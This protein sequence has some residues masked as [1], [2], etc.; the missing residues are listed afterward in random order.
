VGL[1]GAAA[2]SFV[3]RVNAGPVILRELRAEARRPVNHWLRVLAAGAGVAVSGIVTASSR[4]GPTLLG[5][6]LFA[7]LHTTLFITFLVVVPLMTADCVSQE[8]REGTLGLLFLTP[9]T[10]PDIIVGKSLVHIV[11]ALTLFLAAMPVLTLPFL[12]GGVGWRDVA[13]AVAFEGCAVLLGTAAGLL[14]TSKGGTAM[15]VMAWSEVYVLLLA[16]AFGAFFD[17]AFIPN[18][19]TPSF[20]PLAQLVALP[21][22]L[23]T[24]MFGTGGWSVQ[25]LHAPPGVRNAWLRVVGETALC[26]LALFCLVLVWS[27]RRLKRTWQDRGADSDQPGWVRFFSGSAFWRAVFRWNKSRTLDRNPIAWLQEYSWTARLTKWGWCLL[28]LVVEVELLTN[29]RRPYYVG[30][31][32][33]ATLAL[34]LGMSFSAV[35]SFRRERRSGLLELL[36]VT[37]LTAG[38]LIGGRLWGVWCHFFP[39]VAVLMVGW[40]GDW[41]LGAWLLVPARSLGAPMLAVLMTFATLPVIGLYFS[42]RRLH[43]LVAWM[44]TL[45][46]GLVLP[47]L[48]D[49]CVA[50]YS[51]PILAGWNRWDREPMTMLCLFQALIACACLVRL[52]ED[53]LHRNFEFCG[54]A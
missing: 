53:L 29:W 25:F 51:R 39:A 52:Y 40:L 3:A 15:Q 1:P 49:L 22:V 14:A 47:F 43:L 27:V 46:A 36:L 6:S 30:W 7:D 17:I 31:Q 28:I 2:F 32:P 9:L 10:A 48:I 11:R 50:W 23:C 33:W 13:T 20:P 45:A 42:V 8:R 37:P 21:Y 26:C 12:L 34:V 41:L 19:P 54:A 24:G 18:V 35:A 44:A 5:G 38:Q 16:L 4:L